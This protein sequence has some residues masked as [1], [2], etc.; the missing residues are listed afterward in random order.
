MNPRT[1]ELLALAAAA[2]PPE[3]F[4]E[5]VG[6]RMEMVARLKLAGQPA[7]QVNLQ[8]R[9]PLA[10]WAKKKRKEKIAAKSR[11]RNRNGQR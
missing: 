11:R 5:I 10:G 7:A 8:S 1:G 9:S 4:E 6:K 2:F 3:G